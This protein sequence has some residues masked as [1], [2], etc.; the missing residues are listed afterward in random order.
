MKEINI[1]TNKRLVGRS[2]VELIQ[3]F[4][5]FKSEI[6]LEL[7]N[8]HISVKSLLGILSAG[9]EPGDELRFTIMDDNDVDA[10]LQILK[11]KLG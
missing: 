10:A 6:Y 4:T 5:P 1:K 8:R 11:E 7:E 9:I 2:A 3:A